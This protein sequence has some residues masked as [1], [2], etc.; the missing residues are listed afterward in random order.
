MSADP[1]TPGFTSVADLQAQAGRV[2]RELG[3]N[4]H[5]VWLAGIGALARAQSEGSRLFEQLAEEGRQVEDGETPAS[6]AAGRLE[7]LRQ[8]LDAAMGRA[9]TRAGEAWE[10]MGRVFEQR[11]QQTLRQLDVPTRDD[12]DALGA[13]I[14]A[15]TRELQRTHAGTSSPASGNESTPS[16]G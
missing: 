13:R 5:Q 3:D 16:A 6:S 14:D 8:N 7:G 9:Q 2:A 11:V 1:R 12:L 4:A 15:L 10:S